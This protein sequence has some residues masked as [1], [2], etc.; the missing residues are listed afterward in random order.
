MLPSRAVD[1]PKPIAPVV[2]TFRRQGEW[3]RSWRRFLRFKPAVAGLA[4]IAFIALLAIFAPLFS[5][6]NPYD[7]NTA[8]IG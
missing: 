4:M 2:A 6:Y 5:P 8:T 3:R 7:I 1:Q